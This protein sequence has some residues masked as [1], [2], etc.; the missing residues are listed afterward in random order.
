[1]S[2]YKQ[3]TVLIKLDVVGAVAETALI[4]TG[5]VYMFISIPFLVLTIWAL[6]HVYLRTSRQLR[7]LDLESRSPLYSHFLD[8]LHGLAVI[9][10]F[11][12]E[13]DAGRRAHELIDSSQ[14]PFY[15]LLCVQTWLTLVLDLIVG[16]EALIMVGLTMGLR[17]YTS[18][19]LLGVSLN[20]VLCK[21]KTCDGLSCIQIY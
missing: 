1:M 6:Q 17:S 9:R 13:S 16:T 4:A 18:A 12:W 10:A 21:Q 11:G 3:L 20:N 7:L 2:W 14:R 19:G 8:T 5:S 15:L